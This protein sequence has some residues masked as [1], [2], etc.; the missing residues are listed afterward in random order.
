MS[1]LLV[2]GANGGIGRQT[3]DQALSAGHWV[4]AL[5]RNPA[6]LLFT[7]PNLRIVQAD[8]TQPLSLLNLFAGHD[9]IISVIGVSGGFSDPPT[10]LYSQGALNILREMKQSGLRRAFF[11]SA[12]AVETN[13]LL[14]FFARLASKY[15]VQKLLANMYADLRLMERLVKETELDWTIVR[16]PRLTDSKVTGNYRMAVNRF[17]KNGLK[18]SR[19]DTAHFMLSHIQ[20]EDMFKSVVE[21]GY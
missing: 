1:K 14:P 15:I 3:V 11:I 7:H 18:I 17:L 12:S 16:P 2:I 20:S 5:V 4:T 19:A 10:R 13:P 6:K 8:V 9:V 21:I